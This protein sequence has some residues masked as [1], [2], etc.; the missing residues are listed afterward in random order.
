VVIPF[1]KKRDLRGLKELILYGKTVQ[2]STEAKY[3]G[4][5]LDKGLTWGA[6][7]DKVMNRAYRAFWSCRGSIGKTW[8]PKLK[9]VQ[10]VYTMVVRP[11]ITYSSTVWWPRVDIK[12]VGPN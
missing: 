5:V 10:R 12:L 3:L 4:L 11:A 7:P 8:G 1:T 2:L 9:I 6:Q